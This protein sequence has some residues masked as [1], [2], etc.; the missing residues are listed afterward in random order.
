MPPSSVTGLASGFRRE[1]VA[2]ALAADHWRKGR[3][4]CRGSDGLENLRK[5]IEAW[6]VFCEPRAGGNILQIRKQK[7]R[8]QDERPAFVA[9]ARLNS[10]TSGT[11]QIKKAEVA[12]TRKH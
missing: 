3:A 2:T 4:S 6:A 5:L 1:V 7:P 12:A 8:S 9:T 10:L 11:A